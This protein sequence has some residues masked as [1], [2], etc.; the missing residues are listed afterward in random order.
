[1]VTGDEKW[2]TYDNIVRKRSWSKGGEA[3]QTVA[4]LGLTTRK[5]LQCIWWDWKGII[6]Y[7]LLPYGQT[8]N[9]DPYCQQLDR[10]KLAIDQNW[11]T[12]EVDNARP[13]T[14]VVTPQKL[15]E[16]GWEILMHPPYSPDL[17]LSDYYLFLALQNFLIDK[18]LRS[19][20]DWENRLLEFLANKGQD[21]HKRGNMVTFKMTTNYA[22]KRYI[23]D[24]N[25][26]IRSMINK[27]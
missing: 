15:W 23:F 22:T 10:L 18:K 1:M 4:K 6:Y 9:S 12:E 24:S 7:E 13:H 25:R 14:S 16:L 26:T 20:E 5:V 19:R 27:V 17:V 8:L 2:V 3:V 21:F 11:P